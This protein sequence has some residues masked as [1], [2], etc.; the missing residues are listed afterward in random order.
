MT[1]DL[2]TRRYLGSHDVGPV[3]AYYS[4]G[5]EA[6]AQL[7]KYSTAADV[8]MRVVHGISKPKTSAMARGL[9]VEPAQREAYRQHVGPVSEPPGVIVHPRHPWACASPDGLIDPD[10]CLEIKSVSEFAR[11]SWGEPGTDAIPDGYNIQVQWLLECAGREWAHIW[12]AFGR[13]FKD[14]AGEPDFAITETAVYFARR[15]AALAEALRAAG[16]RFWREHVET[17]VPPSVEPAA[18]KREWKRLLQSNGSTKE[19]AN[20]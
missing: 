11:G 19:A 4:P 9:K 12:A 20:G 8:W 5:N 17:G 13:D 15:D 14:E 6:L 18:N 7:T 16:E 1:P 10:G 2:A 3:L